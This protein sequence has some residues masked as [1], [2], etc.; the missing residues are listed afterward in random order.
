MATKRPKSIK[1]KGKTWKVV[2]K[3][4]ILVDGEEC[5]GATDTGE[6]TIEIKLNLDDKTFVKTFLHE[7]MHAT[8]YEIHL[9]M[10]SIVEEALV[11]A[12]TDTA[13]EHFKISLK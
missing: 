6:R 12:F 11:Q 3:K 2:Y 9:D 5:N 1:I 4:I 7:S 10:H 8:I 13:V